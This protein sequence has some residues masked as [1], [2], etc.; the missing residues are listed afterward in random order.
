MFTRT[1]VIK[2]LKQEFR[3]D[4]TSLSE[5]I[6]SKEESSLENKRL[7]LNFKLLNFE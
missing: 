2:S 3:I 7:M 1:L 5:E 4:K 6:N